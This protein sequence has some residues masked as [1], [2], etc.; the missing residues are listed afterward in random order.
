MCLTVPS[1]KIK[2]IDSINF[3]PM[4]LAKLPPMFGFDELK[5]G[6]FPHLFNRKEN[7]TVIMN[8]LPDIKYYCV[9]AMKP[10]DRAM[11]LHWYEEHRN[12]KFDLQKELLEQCKSD[13]D[14]LKH[15]CLR[16][17][18]NFMNITGID[19]FERCITI[20]S[21]CNLVFRTNF[22]QPETIALIPHQCDHICLNRSSQ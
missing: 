13:V 6:N 10:N 3:L 15:C 18:E 2:M 11:F 22:L 21:A 7:Q 8:H 16:F 5:K 20:A 17:R 12:D 19:P 9:D 1:C 4:A 14:I